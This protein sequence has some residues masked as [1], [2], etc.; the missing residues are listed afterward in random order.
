[1]QYG[2]WQCSAMSH[3]AL[4]LTQE[5]WRQGHVYAHRSNRMW[6]ILIKTGI[7]PPGTKGPEADDSM[8]RSVGVVRRG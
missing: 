8:P 4:G 7:A 2:R 3:R 1:M 5:A 6:P